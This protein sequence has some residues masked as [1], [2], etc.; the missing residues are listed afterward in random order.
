MSDAP[1][2][3]V[4]LYDGDC[5]FCTR[6]RDRMIPRDRDRRVEWVSVHDPA[7]ASR[8]P[9]LDRD[10]AL[11]Q[12][13]VFAP[14]GTVHK[15]AEGWMELFRILQGTS[16]LAAI[17]RLPGIRALTRRVYRYIAARRYRLSCATAGCRVPA[18]GASGRRPRGG[19]GGRERGGNGGRGSTTLLLLTPLPAGLLAAA[20]ALAAAFTIACAG[21]PPDPLA[22]RL[23]A[24]ADPES[25]AVVTRVLDAYGG[26]ANW[27][28]HHNAEYTYH[29]E[30]Y[31][32]QKTPQKV[33]RQ[34]HRL[35][36]GP[37]EQ[38]YVEDLD[39]EAPQIVRLDGEGL[40]VTRGGVPVAD[41][42]DLDFPR[43][44]SQIAR[45]SFLNPWN[46]LDPQSLL[47]YRGV[48]TPPAA[49]QVPAGPCEVVRLRFDRGG[50]EGPSLDWY[51]FY[52]NRLSL[53][54]DRIHSYRA[55]DATYRVSI[56]SDHRKFD[57]VR[58]ATRRDTY[59][60]DAGGA[61]GPL[62]VVAEYTDVRFDAPFT[63][64]I[65]R[66]TTPLA[67]SSGRE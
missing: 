42:A 26:Y 5:A 4:V 56:W 53:L 35:G 3:H 19:D 41:P 47:E 33:T 43:A 40:E 23:E 62:E 17:G 28:R 11:R 65:F 7:V 60:S 10:D 20:A 31:G 51:D 50:R 16:W 63:D 66:A 13:Y 6:W 27:M 9:H 48:R 54:L 2:R 38:A 24:I 67:A 52:V 36:L 32:G 25:A 21:R 49:G 37:R 39:L 34:I 55:E 46:L 44:F 57:D 1:A 18:G 59:S 29:L 30:F 22:E 8:Y 12:M 45:W 64:D 14:D 61:I 15:G 58:V